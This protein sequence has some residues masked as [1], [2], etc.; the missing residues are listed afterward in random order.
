MYFELYHDLNKQ[1]AGL[2]NITWLIIPLKQWCWWSVEV[3]NRN[4]SFKC[5]YLAKY[6]NN[7]FHTKTTRGQFEVHMKS[8]LFDELS[9]VP[10]SNSWI[11]YLKLP[12]LINISYETLLPFL[13]NRVHYF[14]QPD[15]TVKHASRLACH[16]SFWE[17]KQKLVFEKIIKVR[18]K[19]TFLAVLLL[20]WKFHL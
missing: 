1:K 8:S 17:A 16:P 15:V 12:V 18:L 2:G 4:T 13:N 14:G 10:T 7:A 19:C 5:K 20:R 6:K 3:I 11:G 9:K